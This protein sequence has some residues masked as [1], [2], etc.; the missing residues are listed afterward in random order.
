MRLRSSVRKNLPTAS[1]F[2]IFT[3]HAPLP[4]TYGCMARKM[5][6]LFMSE[7]LMRQ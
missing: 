1:S 2:L 4:D 5:A 3:A 7:R 6:A